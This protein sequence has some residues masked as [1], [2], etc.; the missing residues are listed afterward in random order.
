[1]LQPPR[2][3]HENDLEKATSTI[4]LI[5]CSESY[6]PSTSMSTPLT[7]S[8]LKNTLQLPSED[9]GELRLATS[10]ANL[11]SISSNYFGDESTASPISKPKNKLKMPRFQLQ[12]RL[13][14]IGNSFLFVCLFVCLFL[15]ITGI[16]RCPST[17][18]RQL[19]A[20]FFFVFFFSR[21]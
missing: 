14:Q 17:L 2:S 9:D 19:N 18:N 10:E 12:K 1:M 7:S 21:G 8:N 16:P 3:V 20:V 5:H 15:L 4:P 13:A 6:A 11:S